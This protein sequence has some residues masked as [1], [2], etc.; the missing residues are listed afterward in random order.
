MFIQVT[1]QFF[2]VRVVREQEKQIQAC[3]HNAA[4]QA[5]VWWSFQKEKRICPYNQFLTYCLVITQ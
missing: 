2:E 1:F 4:R 3:R 5:E